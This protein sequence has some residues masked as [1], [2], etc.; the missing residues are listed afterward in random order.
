MILCRN[1][2]SCTYTGPRVLQ[3]R[4][5]HNCSL[6]IPT[7]DSHGSCPDVKTGG[8]IEFVYN[9]IQCRHNCVYTWHGFIGFPH[10]HIQSYFINRPFQSYFNRWIP[11]GRLVYF[12]DCVISHNFLQLHPQ[13]RSYTKRYPSGRLCHALY[14]RV[15]V[16]IHLHPFHLSNT[17]EEVSI[18]SH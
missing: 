10:L 12:L 4:W 17:L 11:T 6:S 8:T 14:C 1:L 18:I 5:C 15:N 7:G 13:F 16:Q 3:T 2:V 9:I